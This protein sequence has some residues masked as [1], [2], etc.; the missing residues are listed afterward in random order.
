MQKP[1]VFLLYS[2]YSSLVLRTNNKILGW[3]LH[4]AEVLAVN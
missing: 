2:K 1:L 3:Q 4:D